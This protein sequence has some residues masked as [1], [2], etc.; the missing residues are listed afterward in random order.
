MDP[1]TGLESGPEVSPYELRRLRQ[2]DD[3]VRSFC[4]ILLRENL[5]ETPAALQD[6]ANF[7]A[8]EEGL[9]DEVSFWWATIGAQLPGYQMFAEGLTKGQVAFQYGDFISHFSDAAVEILDVGSGPFTTLGTSL[10]G[11]EL[12]ISLADPLAGVF[13]KI[14]QL[15]QIPWSFERR[16]CGG[17]SLTE[18]YSRER[19]HFVLAR[20][21][22]DH[23][24]H[25]LLCVRQMLEVTR[26]RGVVLIRHYE[27]E[28]Q[29]GQYGGLHQW[30]FTEESG[31]AVIW[32]R[33]QKIFL[34]EELPAGHEI[35][36]TRETGIR[37]DGQDWEDNWIE[38]VIRK[39]RG[40]SGPCTQTT[41]SK[42]S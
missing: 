35:S 16:V 32:N 17:E 34:D 22:L 18:V 2:A 36:V 39:P 12:K 41:I 8:W 24:I 15:F 38:I 10:A 37:R 1:H 33:S 21:S 19:F 11:R 31:R 20:N 9:L 13:Q 23:S 26:A 4:R 29:N 40:N 5:P 42:E 6:E 28:A 25:P 7:R 27:N 3:A 14:L 30:N